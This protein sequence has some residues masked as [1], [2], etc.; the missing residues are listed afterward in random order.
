MR[1]LL[2][3][4]DPSAI[5]FI[6]QELLDLDCTVDVAQNTEDGFQKAWKA[7]FEIILLDLNVSPEGSFSLLRAWRQAGLTTPVLALTSRKGRADKVRSLDV[8]ADDC[9]ARPFAFEELLARMRALAR[10]NGPATG[11][12]LRVGDL[13]IDPAM[14]KVSRAGRQISLSPRE[15]A[16]LQLLAEHKGKVVSRSKIWEHLYDGQPRTASNVVDVY[17]R[18]LRNKIDKGESRPLIQT[19]WGEGYFLRGEEI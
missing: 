3:D 15:F 12:A 17:I 6:R 2:I 5:D 10:R 14:R 4:N 18:Y 7:Q 11:A 16:L 1:V 9:L 13:E 8:G 19:R